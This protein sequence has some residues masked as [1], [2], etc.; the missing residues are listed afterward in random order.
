MQNM[1]EFNQKGLISPS[2][3]A[4]D[5]LNR[6]KRQMQER[7]RQLQMKKQ[8]KLQQRQAHEFAQAQ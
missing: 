3:V 2:I 5:N 4:Q 6:V 8:E 7:Q 1:L